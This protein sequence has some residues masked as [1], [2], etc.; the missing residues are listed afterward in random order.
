M[1]YLTFA[2]VS[3]ALIIAGLSLSPSS[4]AATR[5]AAGQT[6]TMYAYEWTPSAGTPTPEHPLVYHALR[7]LADRFK[8]ETGITIKFIAPVCVSVVQ[9]CL[10]QTHTYL[11]T[12]VAANTA[13]DIA[14]VH[15][16]SM[17][18][19]SGYWLNLDPYLSKP[20]PYNTAV[21]DWCHNFADSDLLKLGDT[22]RPGVQPSSQGYNFNVPLGGAYPGLL[23]G[24][25]A[26][27]DLLKKA[28][29]TP[30]IPTDWS[31][32][33]N[34]LATIKAKGFNA[35]SGETSHT[36][37]QAWSWPLWSALWPAYMGHVL[38]KVDPQATLGGTSTKDSATQAQ[39][40]T[41]IK[42]GIIS[43]NDPMYQALY[44]QVKKYMSYWVSGWQ[45]A[46]VE[47]LWTQGKLAERQFYIGDLFTEYSNPARH[48]NMTISFPPYPTKKT[49]PRVV[50]PFGPIPTGTEARLAR[51]GNAEGGAFGI[52]ASAVKR[53][54]NAAAAVKWLEFIT[55]PAQDQYII[56]EHPDLVPMA[57]GTAM[58]PIYAALNNTPNPDWRGYKSTYWGGLSSDATPNEEKEMAVWV[59]GHEDDK[60]FFANMEKIMMAAADSYIASEKK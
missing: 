38:L 27:T 55:A 14:V 54:N 8:A 16:G 6:V 12:Q 56:N 59:T 5:A 47:A 10:N 1:R 33:L 15:N 11:Q 35:M 32:W 46:D 31:D 50:Q 25:M 40:A 36:G 44:Q 30:T 29:V 19:S 39:Q 48:F 17:E 18:A 24:E 26:N 45:T 53:D 34:Q 20:D 58:A 22:C 60:T 52:I 28:G 37:A 13:P 7:V 43:A 23:I 3:L 42:S 21:K 57:K 2:R 41:A 4:L 51:A 49:D 9:A